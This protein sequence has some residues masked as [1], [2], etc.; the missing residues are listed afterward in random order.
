[1]QGKALEERIH[2]ALETTFQV[3]QTQTE[4]FCPEDSINFLLSNILMGLCFNDK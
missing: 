1:M 4:A 3:L 2:S